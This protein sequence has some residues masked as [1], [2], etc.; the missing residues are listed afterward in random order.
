MPCLS[1]SSWNRCH[2][3]RDQLEPNI[4]AAGKCILREGTNRPGVVSPPK[5]PSREMPV[6]WGVSPLPHCTVLALT[7]HTSQNPEDKD[8]EMVGL[9]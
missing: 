1:F 2:K 6:Q 7:P 8:M 4:K 3:V 9:G 5:N